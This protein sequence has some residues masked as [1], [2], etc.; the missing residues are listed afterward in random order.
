[1]THI[2]SALSESYNKVVEN[3]EDKIDDRENL[4]TTNRIIQNIFV[5]L[6]TNWHT[7]KNEESQGMTK[8]ALQEDLIKGYLQKLRKNGA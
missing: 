8:G 4:I 1:M 7:H 3:L 2:L 6:L 5:T